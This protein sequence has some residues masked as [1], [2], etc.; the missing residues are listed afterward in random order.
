[1]S[2]GVP[3][4]LR[5]DAHLQISPLLDQLRELIA[6][7]PS[8]HPVVEN[9]R[10]FAFLGACIRL[11]RPRLQRIRQTVEHRGDVVV[12]LRARKRRSALAPGSAPA[13]GPPGIENDVAPLEK[14]RG[15]NTKLFSGATSRKYGV[16]FFRF[17][18][19]LM[20]RLFRRHGASPSV[21]TAR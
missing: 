9:L 1:M 3:L 21:R 17:D 20:N 11:V 12:E 13:V 4:Q 10:G 5:C 6:L 15:E 14:L 16:N 19:I 8:L 2:G 18:V 7:L